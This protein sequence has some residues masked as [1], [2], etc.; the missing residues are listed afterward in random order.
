MKKKPRASAKRGK[1]A[2]PRKPV[3][4]ETRAADDVLRQ[5]LR[6]ADLKVFDKALEKAFAPTK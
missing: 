6:N 4:A 5:S 1:R 2:R 3:S